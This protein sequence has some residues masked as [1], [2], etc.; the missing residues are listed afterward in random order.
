MLI[1]SLVNYQYYYYYHYH[2]YCF[3]II[4]ATKQFNSII[5]RQLINYWNK[6]FN[7]NNLF[8]LSWTKH[9]ISINSL[10]QSIQYIRVNFENLSLKSIESTYIQCDQM[11]SSPSSSSSSNNN[12]N[13]IEK[14]KIMNILKNPLI[15]NITDYYID[16]TKKNKYLLFNKIIQILMIIILFNYSIDYMNKNLCITAMH[17]HNTILSPLTEKSTDSE[18]I[19]ESDTSTLPKYLIESP[20]VKLIKTPKNIQQNY[21][22]NELQLENKVMQ[23]ISSIFQDKKAIQDLLREMNAYYL[24]YGRPRYG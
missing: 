19:L 10:N 5:I 22:D 21:L 23:R 2:Y 18:T 6:L 3:I 16:A 20:I 7:N 24:T 9:N 12:N 8:N 1:N 11:K 4:Y 15:H 17:L 13:N 14:I